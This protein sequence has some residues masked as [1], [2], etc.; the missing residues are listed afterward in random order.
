M[1]EFG[2]VSHSETS[3]VPDQ[4]RGL[5][6]NPDDVRVQL[7]GHWVGVAV[8]DG[9]ELVHDFAPSILVGLLVLKLSTARHSY[10]PAGR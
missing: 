4:L 6:N 5:F 9:T 2:T 1:D 7:V 10:E 8:A 3:P